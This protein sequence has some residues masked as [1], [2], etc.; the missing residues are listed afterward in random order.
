[1]PAPLIAALAV[2]ARAIAPTVA[3]SA[4]TSAITS[5]LTPSRSTEFESGRGEN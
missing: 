4:A 2:G 1:M 3:R 5:A